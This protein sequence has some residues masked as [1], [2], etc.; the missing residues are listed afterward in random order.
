MKE[1]IRVAIVGAS[2]YSGEELVR[3]LL[4][5]PS[6]ELTK[7]TSRAQA[8]VALAEFYGLPKAPAAGS[9]DLLFSDGTLPELI[10]SADVF[11]LALP[12]GL[13]AEYAVP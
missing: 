3:C 7:V 2:G 9:S 6:V 1:T 5:H 8:G 4:R 11:F 13:A 12:H 10:A